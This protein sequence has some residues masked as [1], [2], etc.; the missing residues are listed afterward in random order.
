MSKKCFD[1]K[2]N[3]YNSIKELCDEYNIS[4]A[5]YNRKVKQGC[6][7]YEILVLRGKGKAVCDHQNVRYT[8]TVEMCKR[9][10]VNVSTFYKRLAKGDTLEQAL[11]STT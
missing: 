9:W 7:L 8:S 3:V 10:K 6:S 4:V 5:T 2:G 11:K 1:H